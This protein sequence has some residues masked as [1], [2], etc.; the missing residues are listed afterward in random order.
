MPAT[1]IFISSKKWLK[2]PYEKIKKPMNHPPNGR[3]F[4]YAKNKEKVQ[5]EG[6]NS[7]SPKVL[8]KHCKGNRC[9]WCEKQEHTYHIHLECLIRE[10]TRRLEW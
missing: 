8:E 2:N 3:K 1:K 6:F 4:I 9:S 10:R 5:Y 7:L